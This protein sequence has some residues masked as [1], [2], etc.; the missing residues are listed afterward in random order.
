MLKTFLPD[1][2]TPHQVISTFKF[3]FFVQNITL[4]FI[5]LI[6]S[7]SIGLLSANSGLIGFTDLVRF[8]D[9]YKHLIPINTF[10]FIHGAV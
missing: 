8:R 10:T 4:N 1:L 7:S 3:L 9:L 2:V 6:S 5:I